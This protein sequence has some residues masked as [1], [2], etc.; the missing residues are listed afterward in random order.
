MTADRGEALGGGAAAGPSPGECEQRGGGQRQARVV[1]GVREPAHRA[2]ERRRRRPGDRG[3]EREVD[4][5][6][7]LDPA[8]PARPGRGFDVGAHGGGIL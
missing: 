5:L 6:G 1:G 8:R 7:V 4:A 3:V 2:V